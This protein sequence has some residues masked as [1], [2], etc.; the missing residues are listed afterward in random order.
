MATLE[1]GADL[2]ARVAELVMGWRLERTGGAGKYRDAMRWVDANGT[3]V[4]VADWHWRPSSDIAE[5]FLVVEKLR[6]DGWDLTFGTNSG[7]WWIVGSTEAD[8]GRAEESEEYA[9]PQPFPLAVARFAVA[10]CATP[11]TP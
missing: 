10:V 7:G 9:T 6:K 5:A 4:H 3:V 11:S 2:D 8:G 1:A